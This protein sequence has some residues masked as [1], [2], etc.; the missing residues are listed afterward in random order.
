MEGFFKSKGTGAAGYPWGG[1]RWPWLS[2]ILHNKPKDIM[3][4]SGKCKNMNILEKIH[5]SSSESE[6]RPNVVLRIDTWSTICKR[7]KKW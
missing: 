7:E 3:N 5:K 2:H 4:L 6:A 1:D